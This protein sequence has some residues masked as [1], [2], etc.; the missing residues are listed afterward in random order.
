MSPRAIRSLALIVSAVGI[1][2]II[3][4][5]IADNNGVAV[6]SGLVTAA[7]VVVILLVTS[8]A[9]P[10]RLRKHPPP[11]LFDEEQAAAVEDRIAHLVAAG[12]DEEEVRAL[13]RA[14]LGVARSVER[15]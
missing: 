12:A 11:L 7:G 10:E 14:V 13:V 8:V 2:G 4:G 6:T 15:T 9:G 5:S 1:A 3:A